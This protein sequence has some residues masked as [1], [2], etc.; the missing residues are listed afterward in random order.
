MEIEVGKEY[1][2]MHPRKG[3]FSGRLVADGG[4]FIEIEIT[5]GEAVYQTLENAVVG[6]RILL[7]RKWVRITRVSSEDK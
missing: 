7:R 4:E 3:V 1:R 2:F 6:D 5:D